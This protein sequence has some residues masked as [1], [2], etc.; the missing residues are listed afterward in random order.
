MSLRVEG[1]EAIGKARLCLASLSISS[2]LGCSLNSRHVG[3][4]GSLH[5]SGVLG[6]HQRLRLESWRHGKPGVS[7][8][9]AEMISHILHSLEL[10]IG[11]HIGVS[12]LDPTVGVA[13]LLL[14]GVDV[15]VAVV[16]VPELVLGVE[17]AADSVW[18]WSWSWSRSWSIG[19]C[20]NWCRGVVI[21]LS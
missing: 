10:A 15:V 9:E 21:S 17:L 12:S 7:H 2:G 14:H 1:G 5:L 18:S 13:H 16:Q 3:S 6:S 8:A 19:H 4:L 11:V 20:L